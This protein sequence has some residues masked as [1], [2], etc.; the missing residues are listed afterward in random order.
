MFILCIC[1]WWPEKQP[2]AERIADRTW[3]KPT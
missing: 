3:R 1:G 2:D